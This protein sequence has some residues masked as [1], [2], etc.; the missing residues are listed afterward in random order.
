[1]LTKARKVTQ[2]TKHLNSCKET[3]DEDEY[4]DEI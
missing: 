3:E 4:D 1:M 2:T